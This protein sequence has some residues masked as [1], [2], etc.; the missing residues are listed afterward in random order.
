MSDPL[1]IQEGSVGSWRPWFAW[2]PVWVADEAWPYKRQKRI[3]LKTVLRRKFHCATW[4]MTGGMWFWQFK[5]I[6]E[7]R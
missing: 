3:W 4:F 5:D 7:D 2:V 1:F 6:G